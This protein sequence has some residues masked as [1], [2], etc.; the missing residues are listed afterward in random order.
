MKRLISIVFFLSTQAVASTDNLCNYLAGSW[1]GTYIF[2]DHKDCRE[3]RGC[4]HIMTAEVKR[5]STYSIE[6]QADLMLQMGKQVHVNFTCQNSTLF[7]P[8][9]PDSATK[10]ACANGACMIKYQDQMVSSTVM[11]VVLKNANN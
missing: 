10:F 8:D 2:L 9:Y 3:N 5:Q 11:H 1:A 4:T 6:F 7:F